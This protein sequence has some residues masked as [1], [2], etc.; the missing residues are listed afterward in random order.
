MGEN[1]TFFAI[2]GFGP[3]KRFK[4]VPKLAP[5]DPIFYQEASER[6]SKVGFWKVPK[7]DLF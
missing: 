7:S 3:E 1:L 4:K 6:F 2:N 5:L